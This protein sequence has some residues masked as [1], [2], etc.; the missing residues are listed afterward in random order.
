MR[1]HVLAGTHVHLVIG[2]I[3]CCARCG[4]SRF[5]AAVARTVGPLLLCVWRAAGSLG[6]SRLSRHSLGQSLLSALGRLLPLVW[7]PSRARIIQFLPVNGSNE[8]F[9]MLSS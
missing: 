2:N 4:V 1:A 8:V 6:R 7:K 5:V 9:E 3:F